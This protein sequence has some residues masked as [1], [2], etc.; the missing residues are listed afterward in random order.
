[1]YILEQE[2]LDPLEEVIAVNS[3]LREDSPSGDHNR[4]LQ[5]YQQQHQQQYQQHQ[6]LR[7]HG[8]N[9]SERRGNRGALFSQDVNNTHNAT[10]HLLQNMERLAEYEEIPNVFVES[11]SDYTQNVSAAP[12]SLLLES[13]RTHESQGVAST[14]SL[15]AGNDSRSRLMSDIP[16]EERL[17]SSQNPH[18]AGRTISNQTGSHVM[19][20]PGL[21]ATGAAG[22]N[23]GHH[24]GKGRSLPATISSAPASINGGKIETC[25]N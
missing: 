9:G 15:N 10:A 3:Q 11:A 1:M 22:S 17:F 20:N 23:S 12:E 6:Q 4:Q 21:V 18:P 5:Q 14:S 2:N 25:T 24:V 19:F 16:P 13:A 8:H 7:L